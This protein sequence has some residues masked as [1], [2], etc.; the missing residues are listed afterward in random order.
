MYNN[1]YMCLAIPGRVKE[2]KGEKIIVEYPGETR[3]ALA[4]GMDLKVD[5]FVLI[6]MGVAIRVVTEKE[7]KTS[8]KAWK[9]L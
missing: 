7:A 5:D 2:I 3:Q 4:G 8:W 1:K 6:Q 9:T